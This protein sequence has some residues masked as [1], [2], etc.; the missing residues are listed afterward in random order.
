MIYMSARLYLLLLERERIAR[1][2]RPSNVVPI[3]R[4]AEVADHRQ[5]RA[6]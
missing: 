6:I 2:V 3:R 5:T 4:A 1:E